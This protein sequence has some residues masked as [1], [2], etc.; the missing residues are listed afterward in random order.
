MLALIEQVGWQDRVSYCSDGC[1]KP[2]VQSNLR[3]DKNGWDING[4]IEKV[5]QES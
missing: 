2:L 5:N 1:P 3:R 4:R